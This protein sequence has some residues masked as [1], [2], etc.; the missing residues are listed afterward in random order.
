[1]SQETERETIVLG[2][3]TSLLVWRA[4]QWGIVDQPGIPLDPPQLQN[5]TARIRTIRQLATV[6]KLGDVSFDAL[7]GKRANAHR[8]KQ[9]HT[10]VLLGELPDGS[11]YNV[12][13]GVY[14]CSPE[15]CFALLGREK[16]LLRLLQ[17]GCEL[18][19]KYAISP[20]GT[21]D[22]VNAP[23]LTT[24][25]KIKSYLDRLGRR[26]GRTF[27]AAALDFIEDESWSPRE[28][29]V[30]LAFTLPHTMGG[31]GIVH[32]R[33]NGKVKLSKR[34]QMAT[35]K[36]F[37]RGDQVFY[38]EKGNAIAVVEY[39]S[40]ENHL[41]MVIEGGKRVPNYKKILEDD[42]RREVLRDED[43]SV[44]TVRTEDIRVF[45]RFEFKALRV[46]KLAGCRPV[47]SHGLVAY[48]RT[49]LFSALF[50]ENDWSNEHNELLQLAGYMRVSKR[51]R[52][53]ARN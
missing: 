38:D 19:G 52:T 35:Q 14:I 20:N 34:G 18:C 6:R 22:F 49:A 31:Y 1:M 30:F 10:I 15:L 23:Q 21:G 25:G 12:E 24:K 42:E 5:C 47:P 11:F 51:R 8:G 48:R 40:D 13:N 27:A 41:F 53:K 39:D 3:V 32:P 4:V 50:S 43:V 16:S 7:V 26:R 45:E 9:L 17:V 36:A 37:I 44:V 2:P 29:E 33:L 28:T 46:A